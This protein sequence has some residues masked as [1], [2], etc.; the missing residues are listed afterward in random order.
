MKKS[1]IIVVLIV[2]TITAN[3]FAWPWT[4]YKKVT[5]TCPATSEMTFLPVLRDAVNRDDKATILKMLAA[6]ALVIL[7]PGENVHIIEENEGHLG[8]AYAKVKVK[9]SGKVLWVFRD[10]IEE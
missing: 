1:I 10:C 4:D 7:E 3:A 5:L 9:S 2:L 6:G 8:L